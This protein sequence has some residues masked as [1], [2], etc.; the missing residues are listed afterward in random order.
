MIV[1]DHQVTRIIGSNAKVVDLN[2][3]TVDLHLSVQK[4]KQKTFALEEETFKL[5]EFGK[6]VVLQIVSF[7][8][9]YIELL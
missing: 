8:S 5:I 4:A 6:K 3:T 1:V 7:Q 9:A 2:T